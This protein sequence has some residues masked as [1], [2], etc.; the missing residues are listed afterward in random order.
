MFKRF[1]IISIAI[2]AILLFVLSNKNG[3]GSGESGDE[4]AGKAAAS[5]VNV[6]IVDKPQEKP[7]VLPPP[8]PKKT[9]VSI[10]KKKEEIPPE[11]NYVDHK[12]DKYYGGVGVQLEYIGQVCMIIGVGKG[13]PA[14]RAG[15]QPGDSMQMVNGDCPGRGEEHTEFVLTWFHLGTKMSKTVIREKICT[16]EMGIKE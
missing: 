14:D 6:K 16:D 2:H 13:Y 5:S 1:L 10:P 9:E 7:E 11:R 15:V 4:K 12:C 8:P 3:N